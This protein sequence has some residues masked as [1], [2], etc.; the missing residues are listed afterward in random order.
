MPSVQRPRSLGKS[1][2]NIAQ[3]GAQ[4]LGDFF[5]CHLKRIQQ[6]YFL[7]PASLRHDIQP[8]LTLLLQYMTLSYL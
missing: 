2:L 7:G 6:L 3:R 1:T 4:Q 5:I 8:H